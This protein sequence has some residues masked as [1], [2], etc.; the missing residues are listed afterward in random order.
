[1]LYPTL[2][3]LLAVTLYSTISLLV[4]IADNTP[5]YIRRDMSVLPVAPVAWPVEPVA[6]APV[7]PVAA[8]APVAPVAVA[9]AAPVAVS[10]R[11]MRTMVIVL[12]RRSSFETRRVIRE[13]WG[14]GHDNVFFAVGAC[15]SVPPSDRVKWT[16]TRARAT[17][18]EDQSR[19]DSACVREDTKLSAEAR[20]HSDMLRMS[21]VDVYRHLPQKLKFAYAWGLSHTTA[22]WFLKTDDDSVVRID[23][24]EDYL[25]RTYDASGAVVVGRIMSGARVPRGGKWAEPHYTPSVYPKFPLGS[26]GH[27]VSRP[28]VSYVV[29]NSDALFNYQG[30]DVSL[31]IW[32]DESPLKLGVSW[33][34]S[35]HMS[36]HGNCR[37]TGMWVMGHNIKPSTM[38]ACFAHKDEM[39]RPSQDV[40]VGVRLRGGL[41]NRLF[42]LASIRGIA[43]AN[44]AIPCYFGSVAAVKQLVAL[45]ITP[46]PSVSYATQK[47]QGYA[48]YTP[49]T[50]TT[51]TTIGAYVQSYKY[52][53]RVPPFVL[54]PSML[55]FGRQYLKTR[56]GTSTTVGIHVR[57]GDHLK[58]GYLQFPADAYFVRAMEYFRTKYRDVQF[59][60]SSN[61]LSWCAKQSFFEGVRLISEEHT[62]AQDMA[63]LSSCDHVIL[64]LGTF[65]WWSGLLSGGEVVY[66]GDE[67][68]MHHRINKG[69]VVKED[70]YPP[71]WVE[72]S[73]VPVRGHSRNTIVTAYFE[74]G[75]SKHST[76]EYAVWM[77]NMLSLQDAMVIFTSP[78]LVSKIASL[79]AHAMDRTKI[80]PMELS[81]TLMVSKYSMD[82]WK[83]QNIKDPEKYHSPELYIIW[84]EKTN[85]LKRAK[86]LNPFGSEFF[87]WV[88]I[89]YFRT[90]KYNH[91]VMLQNI[92]DDLKTTQV[93][94]LDVT[95]LV[96]MLSPRIFAASESDGKYVGA[97]FIGGYSDGI[98]RWHT[99]YYEY[100]DSKKNGFIGTEQPRMYQACEGASSLCYFVSPQKGHGDPWFYMAAYLSN[101]AKSPPPLKHK[102]LHIAEPSNMDR[103]W[104]A[105]KDRVFMVGFY[106]Y[107]GAFDNVLDIGVRKYN[108]RCK[109]LIH[110][111]STNYYQLEPSKPDTM[112][113][114]GFLEC[115]VQ[116]SLQKYPDMF[117]FFDVI[118]DFGVIGW[119]PVID[120]YSDEEIHAYVYNI[121]GMLRPNGIY[122]LK[123]DAS[124]KGRLDVSKFI[125]PHFDYIDFAVYSQKYDISDTETIYFLQKKKAI[126][127]LMVVAHPDDESIFGAT[128][129]SAKTHVIVVTAANSAH[130][131]TQ[132]R[133][134]LRHS[135]RIAGSSFE[136]WD[137][138][139]TKDYRPS[140]TRGWSD[141]IHSRVIEK[142]VQTFRVYKHV[143]R[144]ITHNKWGEYGHIDHRNLH[145]AVYSAFR[146][147]YTPPV[148]MYVFSPKLDY[149]NDVDRLSHPP[150]RCPEGALHK[151]LLDSYERDGSLGNSQL[152]RNLC[153]AIDHF[154]VFEH[155]RATTFLHKTCTQRKRLLSAVHKIA[156]MRDIWYSL[157]QGSAMI[158]L[159]S[160]DACQFDLDVDIQVRTRED[161]LRLMDGVE[162]YSSLHVVRNAQVSSPTGDA[163]KGDAWYS[164]LNPNIPGRIFVCDQLSFPYMD[165]S[166]RPAKGHGTVVKEH[167][168]CMY[169]DVDT[170]CPTKHPEQYIQETYGKDWRIQTL[171][172]PYRNMLSA[173]DQFAGCLPDVGSDMWYNVTK[174]RLWVASEIRAYTNGK[175][176]REVRKHKSLQPWYPE[177]QK[178]LSSLTSGEKAKRRATGLRVKT[179]LMKAL[180]ILRAQNVH[181]FARDGLLIGAVRHNGWI[182]FGGT[183]QGSGYDT[184]PDLLV[185]T[186]DLERF[187]VPKTAGVTL[188]KKRTFAEHIQRSCWNPRGTTRFYAD[189]LG[190]D[191]TRIASV[192]L[193]VDGVAIGL[194]TYFPWKYEGSVIY[195]TCW[196]S[197]AG[198]K[199]AHSFATVMDLAD[200]Y[201]LKY[202][203]FY[204]STLPVPTNAHNIAK[205]WGSDVLTTLKIKDTAKRG[206][207]SQVYSIT[208]PIPPLDI[209]EDI[210]SGV[211][212]REGTSADEDVDVV[213]P[214]SG[215]PARD[216]SGV[217]RDDGIVKYLIRSIIKH[218]PWVRTIFL[219]ADPMPVS[220]WL[221]EFGDRVQ[222]VNRC[223][224]YIGGHCPT[225]N[226]LAVLLNIHTIPGLSEHFIVTDDDIL[227]TK[228]LS[229]DYFFKDGKIS[230]TLT[231]GVKEVYDKKYITM[232]DGYEYITPL[233]PVTAKREPRVRLPKRPKQIWTTMHVPWPFRKS[234]LLDMHREYTD[235][236][237]FVSSHTTRFCFTTSD[238]YVLKEP[239][240][241]AGA[242]WHEYPKTSMIWYAK[243]VKR[244]FHAPLPGKEIPEYSVAYADITEHRLR[245]ILTAGTHVTV[246]INDSSMWESNH[247]IALGSSPTVQA[248]YAERKKYVQKT[249]N[250]LFPLRSCPWKVPVSSHP[251]PKNNNYN[252]LTTL[253]T[254]ASDM[255][256]Y[257][258]PL[259]GGALR[260]LYMY[261]DFCSDTTDADIDLAGGDPG[262]RVPA[263]LK[264]VLPKTSPHIS[265][266]ST[267][268][269]QFG[270]CACTLP[271][272]RPFVCLRDVRQ[273]MVSHY[274]ASWW[275]PIPHL[276]PSVLRGAD[277]SKARVDPV[278]KSLRAYINKDGHIDALSLADVRFAGITG[279]EVQAA[280][281]E[282]EAL[283]ISLDK[284][285]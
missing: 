85:F 183:H 147:V 114:D 131:G 73:A 255:G 69:N 236:F 188:S 208:Q 126:D 171:T 128:E 77:R 61:D 212:M 110:S 81:D 264:D 55:D 196:K 136:M 13:T 263:A 275:V 157:I 105:N 239:G 52:F 166:I 63:I 64:S 29:A 83:K 2:G 211:Y 30:E 33:V 222:L 247:L 269:S 258:G 18:V 285:N 248:K 93:M 203:P 60:V 274:G 127:T 19:W 74:L 50:V 199:P 132:R 133:E 62:A 260:C 11:G 168:P 14:S 95:S 246:N 70:Y 271:N 217:S 160:E 88:D 103:F 218:M 23:T 59:F 159:R 6:P 68:A 40:Y 134:H 101:T 266:S 189:T 138:P 193:Y 76:S 22:D 71:D 53:V 205:V 51:S 161:A 96:R 190:I 227:I 153:Y 27:V 90:T 216:F 204:R 234:I 220:R 200:I 146:M 109:S 54:T 268:F 169:G 182:D 141:A 94:M 154:P 20:V 210:H 175:W 25:S 251:R 7:A 149:S 91:Q 10:K 36:N 47:E 56:S 243:D 111:E 194:R 206:T 262:H 106:P 230:T 129:L 15:C 58:H 272:G 16:C 165:V 174:Q 121:R 38:R 3:L 66:N 283:R 241:K 164:S 150:F 123:I 259:I 178:R 177:L 167:V 122:I 173:P 89:G 45:D 75:K 223:E 43:S 240:N 158:A 156:G 120:N 79:R 280:A 80:M 4:N 125:D 284:M 235:W 78:A 254:R 192:G 270:V 130:T 151:R 135:M 277:T 232:E 221:S 112:H 187:V 252:L 92:P 12:S 144:V 250:A 237:K 249:L 107:L 224:R 34:T 42:M 202:I 98:D 137:F 108:E 282:M 102:K 214:W 65:G 191:L 245:S 9:V 143:K 26:V 176:G 180:K 28:V 267:D 213:I 184:D 41:G 140:N 179:A 197:L 115:T 172:A 82:F 170:F 99:V 24:L 155:R 163:S 278:R 31:G 72:M 215:E 39:V 233:N 225:Q 117:S 100:L 67:F 48:K 8:P 57:R 281:E 1:M 145:K 209:G 119:G 276:K 238:K 124:A 118:N 265:F 139:E 113:N 207:I 35:K 97:G 244:L 5:R 49:F 116:E 186:Y 84:Q 219:F 253:Y 195:P 87:A 257:L 32:L 104:K 181:P 37:D 148:G 261:G 256:V 273:F 201:P 279:T 21:E 44:R 152:F 185:D 229:R 231:G 17:S 162:K 242:C 46:C 142:L 226:G 198:S 228:D 86:D